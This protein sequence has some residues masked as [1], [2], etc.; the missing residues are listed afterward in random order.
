M[1]RQKGAALVVSLVLLSVALMLGLSNTQ[2]SRLEEAMSGNARSAASA[3]M[4][5]EYAISRYWQTI[6]AAEECLLWLRP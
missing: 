5:A 2:S 6:V 1:Q 4:A 3:K